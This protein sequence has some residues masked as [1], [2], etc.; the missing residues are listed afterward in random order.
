MLEVF[1][2]TCSDVWSKT[3][4]GAVRGRELSFPSAASARFTSG[5]L[6][7]TWTVFCEATGTGLLVVHVVSV[8]LKMYIY[9]E[10]K[11][12]LLMM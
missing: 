1:F 3:D 7:G 5:I 2:K 10:E 12:L 11:K 4:G 6:Q 8:L 9:T